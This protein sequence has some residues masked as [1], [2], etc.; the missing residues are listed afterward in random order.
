MKVLKI[1]S[2]ICSFIY[3]L[4]D[5]IVYLANLDF[6][7]PTI[8]GLPGYKWKQI[9][10]YFSLTKTFMEI[11][12]AIYQVHLKVAAEHD[13]ILRLRKF[14]SEIVIWSSEANVLVRQMIG[15]RREAIFHRIEANIFFLRMLMLIKS[16]KIVG[17]SLLNPIF[18]SLCGVAQASLSVYKGMKGK[19]DV[20][21]LTIEDIN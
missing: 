16:L 12:I 6:V 20:F 9:K 4:T 7:Q 8:P 11:I 17:H 1:I 13:L 3:Y 5:N 21:K 10:N 14:N 15:L 2:T 18:V 19:Q